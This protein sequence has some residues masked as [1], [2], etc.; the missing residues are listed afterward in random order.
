MGEAAD[1]G[2]LESHAK[3]KGQTGPRASPSTKLFAELK[4]G[5]RVPEPIEEGKLR[6]SL[7]IDRNG[8]PF[9]AVR[10]V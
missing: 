7:H 3:E 5:G 4:S 10:P 1:L 6:A 9:Q 2:P 8:Y